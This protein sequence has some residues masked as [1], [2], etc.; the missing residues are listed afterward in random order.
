MI[1]TGAIALFAAPAVAFAEPATPPTGLDPLGQLRAIAPAS[2]AAFH[3]M[4][5][6]NGVQFQLNG[7]TKS[8]VF[9]SPAVVRVNA[10]LGQSYWTAPSLVVIRQPEAAPFT[11]Q[12]T[13]GALEL[14]SEKLRV[15][16][17]KHAGALT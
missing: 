5:L 10:N 15:V 14:I 12:E 13:A 7:V 8:V 1:T 16:I 11:V 4:R 9:Y 6:R 17:D 3:F 2:D